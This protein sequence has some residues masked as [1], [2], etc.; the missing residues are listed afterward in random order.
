M[1][2]SFWQQLLILFGGNAMLLAALGFLFKSLLSQMLA[3]DIEKF[4]TELKA[5]ADVEL[6]RH[7]HTLQIAALE[8]Q[9]R[10]AKLHEKRALVVAD[11]YKRFVAAYWAA[12]TYHQW[13]V[14]GGGPSEEDQ[15]NG[16]LQKLHEAYRFFETN[17]IFL[18]P[19]L[20][21]ELDTF[22]ERAK[23]LTFKAQY[24]ASIPNKTEETAKHHHEARREGLD[25]FQ[26][27]FPVARQRLDTEFKKLIETTATEV[28][29]H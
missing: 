16:A 18:A 29:P 7:K 9:V 11:L 27:E 25:A 5:G 10:F 3:K 14:P 23:T 1:N 24:F 8:H 22:F 2:S 15:A 20:T 6:E 17:R 12:H 13:F 26:K 19:T 28:R 4:K 21:S